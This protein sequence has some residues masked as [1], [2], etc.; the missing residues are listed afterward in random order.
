MAINLMTTIVAILMLMLWSLIIKETIIS[1]IAEF[2]YIGMGTALVLY[3]TLANLWSTTLLPISQGSVLRIIPVLLGLLVLF[4]PF[5]D[6]IKNLVVWPLA[7]F[8]SYSIGSATAGLTISTV[9]RNLVSAA[10]INTRTPFDLFTSIVFLFVLLSATLSFTLTFG[11]KG[12]VGNILGKIA[13]IGRYLL[14]MAFALGFG[15]YFL[16]RMGLIASRVQYFVYEWLG[17]SPLI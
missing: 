2:I 4:R 16:S 3:Q 12:S 7:V 11:T 13:S 6:K 9:W 8:L 14:L 10:K 5:S 1:R 15:D 17:L